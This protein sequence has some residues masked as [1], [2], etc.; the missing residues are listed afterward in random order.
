[1]LLSALPACYRSNARTKQHDL[2]D[3]QRLNDSLTAWTARQTPAGA[4]ALVIRNGKV[5]L[6]EAY[7]WSNVERQIPMDTTTLFRMGS[8]AKPILGTG[9]LMLVEDGK[10]CLDDKV[11]SFIPAFAD[12]ACDTL[13]VEHLLRHTSGYDRQQIWKDYNDMAKYR[14]IEAAVAVIAKYEPR[15][16]VGTESYSSVNSALL[17]E[18]IRVVTGMPAEEFLQR[19]LFEPLQ[20]TSSYLVEDP[21]APW[22]PRLATTYGWNDKDG[23]LS[24]VWDPQKNRPVAPFFR[25]GTGLSCTAADY[26]RFL[27]LWLNKGE[28]NGVRLLKEET[29]AMAVDNNGRYFGLH[30]GVPRSPGLDDG[31]PGVFGHRR[32]VHPR[33]SHRSV[34]YPNLQPTHDS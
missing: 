16:P 30:W 12:V 6:H 2:S 21:K 25:G 11:S 18:I 34:P 22:Y 31:T 14:T 9:I 3:V 26:A 13:T 27:Q 29:V 20:M 15:K 23:T 10:L 5:L 33:Q 7:G 8:N 17:T 28:L 1:M 24:A 4:V 32:C 19:R